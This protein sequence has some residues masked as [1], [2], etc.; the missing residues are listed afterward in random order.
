MTDILA[1]IGALAVALFAAWRLGRSGAKAKQKLKDAQQEAKN[2]ETR[3]EVE[4]RI[5]RDGDAKRRLR[6]DWT[7]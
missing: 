3:N 7:Q 4:N 6:D 5:A 1:A 2:H